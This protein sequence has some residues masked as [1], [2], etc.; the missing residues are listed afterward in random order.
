MSLCLRS[1]DTAFV[2][3]SL[4]ATIN[5]QVSN[6]VPTDIRCSSILSFGRTI[7]GS[8]SAISGSGVATPS[9]PLGSLKGGGNGAFVRFGFK[10]RIIIMPTTRRASRK[11]TLRLVYF[12]W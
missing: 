11:R 10:I 2:G 6:N 9:L 1:F 8:E 4:I 5:P 7:S 12:R 3:V